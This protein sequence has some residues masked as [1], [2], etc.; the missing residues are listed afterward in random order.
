MGLLRPRG[1][2]R[3]ILG[4]VAAV[5]ALAG[6]GMEVEVHVPPTG[7]ALPEIPV[8]R[9]ANGALSTSLKLGAVRLLGPTLDVTTRAY[10][11]SVPGP[12]LAVYP[13]EKL[14]VLL[15]ND[16]ESPKG[17]HA[18]EK[19]HK[20]NTTNL[21]VHGLHVSEKPPSDDVVYTILPP[22]AKWR[23]EYDILPTHSPGTYWAHPH[24]HG[25][26]VLEVGGG[27]A[28]PLLVLDPPGFLPSELAAMRER[29]LIFQD[30][31]RVKLEQAAKIA[32]DKLFRVRRW[33]EADVLLLVNGA[34]RPVLAQQPGEWQRL[35]L[36]GASALNWLNLDF[37]D[38]DAA[39]LA[40]DGIYIADFPRAVR[41]AVLAPGAR[42]D[43]AVRC[44]QGE[45]HVSSVAPAARGRRLAPA[46]EAVAF[47]IR[48]EGPVATGPAAGEL[49][50]WS[51]LRPPYLQ[52]LARLPRPSCSCETLM[53]ALGGSKL[54]SGIDDHLWVD[55]H[56]GRPVY[57]HS[58]PFNAAVERRLGGVNKHTYHQ[59]TYPF[60]LAEIPGG[61]PYF[62]VGDWHDSYMN[63]EGANA[64]VRFHTAD[65]AGPLMVHCHNL[66]HSD[67]GM[68]ALE[69]V[70][71][72]EC[73]CDP[74]LK[75]ESSRDELYLKPWWLPPSPAMVVA[76][77]AAAAAVAATAWLAAFFCAY[78]RSS[79]RCCSLDYDALG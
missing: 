52:D 62:Q 76:I 1:Q 59:H 25:S 11:G 33:E 10:N 22:G 5:L 45:H 23:Y 47:S 56:V 63:V 28:S 17:P 71:Q 42:A 79:R 53:G 38:C 32:D 49:H 61:G 30:L 44:P 41:R 2:G 4:A 19:E 73:S 43:L 31:D 68:V 64:V 8:Q 37:G 34:I 29:L 40:K 7:S 72:E 75:G 57:I 67:H 6:V 21:H 46:L 51:P 3:V 15:I 39:L 20:P 60:Q 54:K 48:V 16:L 77:A 55:P 69:H 35:R 18:L 70:G 9:S 65:F 13:G 24:H 14:S 66:A 74:R 26:L 78:K 50:P 58:S 36:I 27:V 12:G